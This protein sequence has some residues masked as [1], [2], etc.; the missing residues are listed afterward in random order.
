MGYQ[1]REGITFCT[2]AGRCIFLDVPRDR[3]FA[4]AAE[5]EQSFLKLAAGEA[6]AESDEAVL[7]RLGATGPVAR[8]EGGQ[9]VLAAPEAP[10]VTGS[11]LEAVDG[12]AGALE[13]MRA[14]WYLRRAT[15][16]LRRRGL[17]GVLGRL[18]ARKRTAA[19]GL[20]KDRAGLVAAGF[21]AA[22]AFS[23]ALDQCLPRSLAVA[24]RLLAIG[25]A[26]DL[27]IG[28]KLQ[29]FQAHCWVQIEGQ[30]V[31]ER[32]EVAKAFTP[33]LVL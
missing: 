11:L 12:Q 19:G 16:S 32:R 10:P 3:Y 23:T 33:I 27:I 7:D 29:P 26:P 1:L 24:A 15:S 18:A 2:V 31:N 20:P 30:L 9:P 21:M 13:T 8:S 25:G 17:A 14:L 4:L 28:V 22:G 6:L 5:A